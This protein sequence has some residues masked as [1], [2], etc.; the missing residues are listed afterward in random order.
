MDWREIQGKW[1]QVAGKLKKEFGRLTHDD[2]TMS[3]GNREILVGRLQERYGYTREV[4]E[5][6]LSRFINEHYTGVAQQSGP[7]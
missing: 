3:E 4:A 5:H 7:K 6:E 2:V 1:H